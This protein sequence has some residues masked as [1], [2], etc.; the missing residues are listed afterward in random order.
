MKIKYIFNSNIVILNF[1]MFFPLL[2]F[3]S[4]EANQV[5][6]VCEGFYI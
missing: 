6:R 2:D 1:L 5:D 4:V 3:F